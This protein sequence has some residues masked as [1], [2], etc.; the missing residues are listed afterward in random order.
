MNV[1]DTHLTTCVEKHVFFC[2][3][4]S[5][6]L[7]WGKFSTSIHMLFYVENIKISVYVKSLHNFNFFSESVIKAEFLRVRLAD[8][9]SLE[10]RCITDNPS[11]N[12]VCIKIDIF[13]FCFIH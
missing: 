2:M 10:G 4:A 8:S 9:I 6:I 12:L 11:G 5:K 13:T 7:V 3:Y 1:Q